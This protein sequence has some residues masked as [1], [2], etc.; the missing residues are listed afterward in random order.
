MLEVCQRCVKKDRCN[1]AFKC[2]RME[3]QDVLNQ[4]PGKGKYDTQR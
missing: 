1:K 4:L 3:Y 2:H